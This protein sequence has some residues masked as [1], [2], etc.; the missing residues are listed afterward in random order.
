MA[1]QY[2][3]SMLNPKRSKHTGAEK[4]VCNREP[5]SKESEL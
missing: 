2:I 4:L 1:T 5:Q 3:R